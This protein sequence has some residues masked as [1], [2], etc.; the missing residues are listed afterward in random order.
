MVA[1]DRRGIQVLV[2]RA[3]LLT[4]AIIILIAGHATADQELYRIRVVNSVSGPVE[5]SADGGKTYLKVGKVTRP[6]TSSSRGYAASVYAV[7]GTVAATAVHSIRIKTAGVKECSRN[8]SKVI[9]IVPLEFA[10]SPTGFGGFTSDSSAICTDIP[11]GQAIFRNLSSFVGN[12]VFRQAGG[13]L[14]PLADGFVPQAGDGLIVIVTLPERYPETI[15][16]ENRA[17]GKVEV[18]Y[19]DGKKTIA[20]VER[21]VRGVGRFDATGYTGVGRINTNHTGVLTISTAPIARGAKDGGPVETRGGF[22]IQPSRHAKLAQEIAQVMIVAPI[23]VGWL[24]GAPPLFSG[25]FGLHHDPADETKSFL[26]DARKKGADWSPLPQV[27]GVHGDALASLTDF[28][29]RFPGLTPEWVKS[30]LAKCSSAYNEVC[31]ARAIKSG[32]LVSGNLTLELPPK[33]LEG[34]RLV[35]LYVDGQFRGATNAR[36]YVFSLNTDAMSKG[37]HS[38][39]LRAVDGSG[40]TIRQL[41]K[42]FFVQ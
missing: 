35:N 4:A 11:T 19:P 16:I 27:V 29:I 6:A 3:K 26:V 28:R 36:P 23:S 15:T 42:V 21:P 22:M 12:R 39:E 33:G 13:E 34:V 2:M 7:P 17:D 9:S 20:K 41:K 5:V 25:H 40:T 1:A 24:E 38:A 18:V 14:M 32:S 31:R 10:Q 30:Q 8:A 37:E